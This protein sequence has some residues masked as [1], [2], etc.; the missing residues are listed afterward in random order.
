MT[1]AE[2]TAAVLGRRLA[3]GDPGWTATADVV[4]IGSG[5]AGLTAALE[6]RSKV[7]RVM[8]VTK[9]ELVSGSTMWAQGGI[10]AAL[11]P[12]DSPAAHLEDTLVAGVGL[13]DTA[14]VSV[15]V[16]EGPARVRE[17]AGLGAVFDRTA[18]G[19]H[20]LTREGGHH[21]DRILHAGGD[22]T[23]AE[24][25]RALAAKLEAVCHDPGIEVIEHALVL[26]VLTSA[27]DADG[28]PGP[29]AGVVLHVIGEGSRDGVGAVLA[30]VVVL[31]TGGIGQ[32]F[33]SSTNPVQATAD[34]MAAALRAGALLADI[35]FVQFHPTVLWSGSGMRGQL[36]LISEAVRGEGALLLD[37]DGVRF[38]PEVHPLAE[39][40]PRDVVSRA[41]VRRMAATG[42]DHVWLD[43]RHLGSE[44]LRRRFPTIVERLAEHHLD[45]GVD[46]IPVAPA[47]HYHSGGVLTDLDGRSSL[48]GLYAVGEVACTGVHGANR[49]AS[50]SL[51]EGLVFAHRAARSIAVDWSAG[52][53]V[54]REP[55]IR[56]GRALVAAA[57][58]PR[59]QRI[60]T[61]GPGVLRSAAGLT[62]AAAKLAAV[63][64]DAH[65]ADG[66]VVVPQPA[67]WETTNIHQVATVLTA[68]ALTR[69][70][71]RGGHVRTDF[72]QTSDDW[73]VRITVALEPDGTIRQGRSPVK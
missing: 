18:D 59:L 36:T 48:P 7:G 61:E 24:I 21:A 39:L 72:P 46:L 20:S 53:F 22:A 68:T 60:A 43:A 54:T 65:R 64:T 69:A 40:A 51:L 70:E 50:N 33:Q 6:L 42:A 31:A 44:F 47:Q 25:S 45:P 27:P 35:E 4:V 57:T 38:M 55:V 10:A 66:V 34:G 26:D 15:L 58:R 14:A 2:Q 62:L 16:N 23:G 13:C 9:A 73:K 5:I 1:G 12:T 8:L 17:L 28:H 56:P 32:V 49:L 41:I 19:H 29:V 3:S 52:R 71:T 37:T 11:A 63:P 30:P 67:E